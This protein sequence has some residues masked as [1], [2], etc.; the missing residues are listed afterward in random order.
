MESS[1]PGSGRTLEKALFMRA[2]PE[3]VFRALTE[4][5]ELEKWFV[6]KAEVDLRPGG[7]L[8]FT[9]REHQV[10]E[11]AFLN[12][13]PPHRLSFRWQM[14]ENLGE[15]TV[16]IELTPEGEGTHVRLV[17][18]G[19]GDG[20]DWDRLYNAVDPGWSFFLERLVAWLEEGQEG[21]IV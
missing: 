10:A 21:E 15:T 18:T 20:D 11:G 8:R 3:R 4:P 12:V 7:I 5:S 17:E 14:D 9:W 1:T 16:T 19:W 6:S 13:D 2:T